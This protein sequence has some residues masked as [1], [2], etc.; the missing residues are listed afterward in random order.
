M[1]SKLDQ[2]QRSGVGVSKRNTSSLK[3]LRDLR[4]ETVF[5]SPVD[6]SSVKDE[7]SPHELADLAT[8]W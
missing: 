7:E 4:E 3:L 1:G 8:P 6:W 5:P 2:K